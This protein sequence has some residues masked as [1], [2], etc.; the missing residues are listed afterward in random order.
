[1]DEV[2]Y[3]L[4]YIPKEA[5]E[6]LCEKHASEIAAGASVWDICPPEY[7]SKEREVRTEK[8][9]WDYARILLPL[10][11]M[12]EIHVFEQHLEKLGSYRSW[13]TVRRSVVYDEDT[14]FDWQSNSD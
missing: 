13:E 9:A 5:V 1:M 8:E 4:E 14:A 6:A 2:R 3:I 7:M 11:E 12:G 10:D